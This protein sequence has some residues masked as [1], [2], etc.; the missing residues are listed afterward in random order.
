MFRLPQT[1]PFQGPRV[2]PVSVYADGPPL[3]DPIGPALRERYGR[4]ITLVAPPTAVTMPAKGAPPAQAP[5]LGLQLADPEVFPSPS[6]HMFP[7]IL[8][9]LPGI[10]EEPQLPC[11]A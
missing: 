9:Y 10:H 3:L 1:M 5:L 4:K 6:V 2:S 11:P 8:P 7:R